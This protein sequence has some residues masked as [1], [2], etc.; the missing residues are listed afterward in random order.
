MNYL[1]G[2]TKSRYYWTCHVGKSA[3]EDTGCDW[4]EWAEMDGEG[5]NVHPLRNKKRRERDDL[6]I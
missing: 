4:F 1:W 3:E 6:A 2:Y 5:E